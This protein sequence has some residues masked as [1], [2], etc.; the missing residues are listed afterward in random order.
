M[1]TH[2]DDAYRMHKTWRTLEGGDVTT[3]DL[4]TEFF[5]VSS[6]ALVS[7][8]VRNR[9]RSA[10]VFCAVAA[11]CPTAMV[12]VVRTHRSD[13]PP[14]FRTPRIATTLCEGS[15]RYTSPTQ[16]SVTHTTTTSRIQSLVCTH[17]H[18]IARCRRCLTTPRP[19]MHAAARF[20]LRTARPA[21]T[22]ASGAV[23]L[24]P[25][26]R[27]TTITSSCRCARG[28]SA[29]PTVLSSSLS[30]PRRFTL[31]STPTL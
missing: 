5:L 17:T 2:K 26:L 30:S 20:P 7:H 3:T 6:S 19:T 25:T 31:R 23:T 29:T 14:P 15:L 13:A 8:E 12:F 16:H 11:S 10:S 24:Q 1:R 4:P 22:S 9:A 28:R 27:S 21:R 18:T